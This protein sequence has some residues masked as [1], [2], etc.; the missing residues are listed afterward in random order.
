MV[1]KKNDVT[2]I[3]IVNI[4]PEGEDFYAYT[5]L[6]RSIRRNRIPFLLDKETIRKL[7]TIFKVE[8]IEDLI[9]KQFKVPSEKSQTDLAFKYLLENSDKNCVCE[10]NTLLLKILKM[11]KK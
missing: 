11:E 4:L 10:S 7:Y 6:N 5:S 1:T 8:K 3:T 9:G 2:I